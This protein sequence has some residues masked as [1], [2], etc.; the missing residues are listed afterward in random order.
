[1]LTNSLA[2]TSLA[3]LSSDA[4]TTRLS[5]LRGAERLS[6]VE[7]LWCLGEMDRR[8]THLDLG[9]PSLFAYCTDALGLPKA[10]A[11][12]RTAAARLLVRFQVAAEYL[13]DGR[14][15]LTTF[16]LLK[17]VLQP[18]NHRELLDR[19]AGRTEEQVEVLVASLRPRLE[20]KESIRRLPNRAP[21]TV[22]SVTIGSGPEPGAPSLFAPSAPEEEPTATPHFAANVRA[23]GAGAGLDATVSVA[24]APNP[25]PRLQPIDGERHSLKMTVGPEF[26]EELKQVKDA[27]SHLV[28]DGNFE[29]VLRVCM[30]KTLELCARRK[31]GARSM[32][33]PA[34]R[35]QAPTAAAPEAQH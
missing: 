24:A 6:L 20:V 27:L 11:Y 2:A 21:A 8:R 23:E 7:F 16:V 18:E 13:A 30:Q 28:P 32:A 3:E 35:P 17:D 34:A 25:R 26:M 22:E 19:A 9:Y 1:M 5:E 10:S 14:L 12:R 15:C 4:L 33:S 29:S 31:R